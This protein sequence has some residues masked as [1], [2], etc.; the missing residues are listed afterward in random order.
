MRA[1]S[2]IG[3][4]GS[5]SL[6]FILTIFFVF[7]A[8]LQVIGA[9]KVVQKSRYPRDSAVRNTD[10]NQ[11]LDD[12]LG[13]KETP[14]VKGHIIPPSS[15]QASEKRRRSLAKE[16]IENGGSRGAAAES[17]V[18]SPVKL[19]DSIATIAQPPPALSELDQ[20]TVK[21][22]DPFYGTIR[23]LSDYELEDY[24]IAITIKGAIHGMSRSARKTLWTQ[25]SNELWSV[26]R[27]RNEGEDE[28]P[29]QDDI[30][31]II[32]PGNGGTLYTHT[33]R[34]GLQKGAFQSMKY[35]SDHSPYQAPNG[36]S[37]TG[38]TSTEIYT[39]N[40]LTG[41]FLSS[42]FGSL[43]NSVPDKCKK[44]TRLEGLDD[45]ECT[46]RK[47]TLAR[48]DYTVRIAH[49]DSGQYWTLKYT[50]WGI[51]K[52]NNDLAGQYDTSLDGKYFHPL[53]DGRLLCR[54]VSTDK[55]TFLSDRL[56]EPVAQI[57][58]I[59][60][61]VHD[62]SLVLLPHPKDPEALRNDNGNRML[63]NL[64][65]GSGV[66]ALPY[67]A[68]SPSQSHSLPERKKWYSMDLQ[69][70]RE[71]IQ[72]LRPIRGFVRRSLD[73][74]TPDSNASDPNKYVGQDM[75]STTS[76]PNDRPLKDNAAFQV[77]AL[78]IL[79]SLM[80]FAGR[81]STDLS[82]AIRRFSQKLP[83]PLQ[84][85]TTRQILDI[86]PDTPMIKETFTNEEVQAHP[87]PEP[88]PIQVETGV[89][90]VQVVVKEELPPQLASEIKNET[91]PDDFVIVP[92]PQTVPANK[93]VV[94]FIETKEDQE[95]GSGEDEGNDADK[96]A[97]PTTPGKKKR[98]RGA[99]GKGKR[100]RK[101]SQD[102]D[103]EGEKRNSEA[104]DKS[105]S[106]KGTVAVI[107]NP[108]LL[109]SHINGQIAEDLF[110]SNDVLGYGSHGTRVYR[111]K[112][113]DR[114]VAVKRLLVD[115]YDLASHEVNLLQRVDDHPN[116][117]RYFCQKQTDLFLYI[118]LELCPASLQD[119]FEAPQHR[120][121]LDLMEP[122]E[123]LRQMTFGV[124]HLHSLKIVHRDLKPQN[125]LVAE[126]KSN[127]R[128]SEVKHPKILISDFG[129][130]K[131]LE[132]DQSS[133]R[134]TTAHAA[135]TSGWR[136]PELLIGESGDA[137]ISSLSEHTNG[138]TSDSSVLDTLTNR[139]ATRAIDIF[140]LGCVF[141]FVLT[142]GSHPF[143]DRY[144]REGNII[145]GKY[146][147]SGLDVL[148]D[149]GAE[150]GD[151]IAS[152]IARNPKARP[153]ATAVLTHPFFWSADKKLTFLLDVS[154]R[155]E[156][157]ER[158]PPSPLL[159]RLESF[160]KPT[161]G[162][163]WYKKLDK[164]FIDNLGKHRKYQGDRMLDL[165]RALRNK[166]HHY[167]DLPPA[168]QATVGALPDGYL[169]Y[170]TSKFPTLLVHMFH[171]VRDDIK[172]EPMWRSYFTA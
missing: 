79:M 56:E 140:S 166:K 125:I 108:E 81:H 61:N 145:T 25:P 58:D 161:F 4:R 142:R 13:K 72:G 123:V 41:D 131:K 16:D 33:L 102:A 113:G 30:D 92:L 57:F 152:M 15:Y 22:V 109:T 40:P 50:E 110:V 90:D 133:F 104:E 141:Y 51:G 45:E 62:K 139:R 149:S 126:P 98:S 80:W 101:K 32:E 170:F 143:G 2:S 88:M 129:L 9:E 167:Q 63:A 3:M 31:W 26:E 137:T 35:I 168:V 159:Q 163:D 71:A 36:M 24:I 146:N 127:L 147:L 158:D 172:D 89:K 76:S 148:G 111:G 87:P 8:L 154:D 85:D 150:A 160:A 93:K 59:A 34:D 157:E 153:D 20:N 100:G 39:I 124:Q 144:L 55:P 44:R 91:T 138:S 118:A 1:S 6:H 116:V 10:I 114:E 122:P 105:G 19:E 97:T 119:V 28:T 78:L 14:P 96:P 128:T 54:D 21:H 84:S 132:N 67:P 52:Q 155:F 115:S 164:C 151:L 86:S 75:V 120:R 165:L 112:F 94:A 99:R 64:E 38:S 156:K 23:S 42:S 83:L 69:G 95:A 46:V 135:G 162:V 49:T 60:S 169:N 53:R 12:S 103:A 48:T 17:Y 136:A 73:G 82:V 66:F 77:T 134:A 68:G 65:G 130:C 7:T 5:L 47:V 107:H 70:R 171:L 29:D 27:H 121:I 74:P 106:D 11:Q 117:V 37:L 43:S 18:P